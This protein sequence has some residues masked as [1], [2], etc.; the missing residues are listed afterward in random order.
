[1]DG[2]YRNVARRHEGVSG[3]QGGTRTLWI[4]KVPN[5]HRRAVLS[6]RAHAK[7]HPCRCRSIRRKFA[8][9]SSLGDLRFAPCLRCSRRQD[10]GPT[11]RR[12]PALVRRQSAPSRVNDFSWAGPSTRQLAMLQC[13]MCSFTSLQTA[14]LTVM[15]GVRIPNNSSESPLEKSIKCAKFRAGFLCRSVPTLGAKAIFTHTGD[16][17]LSL[18]FGGTQHVN[19]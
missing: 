8:R 11:T 17:W 15:R 19:D 5:L 9:D 3:P 4:G 10:R 14:P 6:P 16:S 1:M 2:R 12:R 18:K 13:Q 7:A